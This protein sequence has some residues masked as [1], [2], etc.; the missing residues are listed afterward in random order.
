MN[1]TILIKRSRGTGPMTLQQPSPKAGDKVLIPADQ[2]RSLRD[3]KKPGETAFFFPKKA[4][5]F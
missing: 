1:K 2:T 3:K 4:V 5:I